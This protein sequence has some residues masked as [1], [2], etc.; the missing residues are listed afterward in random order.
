MTKTTRNGNSSSLFECI[1]RF[2]C[3]YADWCNDAQTK[4]ENALSQ[5]GHYDV[6]NEE[7]ATIAAPSYCDLSDDDVGKCDV[8]LYAQ[9]N[10]PFKPMPVFASRTELEPKTTMSVSLP[11]DTE[12]RQNDTMSL[13][14]YAE[15]TRLRQKKIREKQ[16]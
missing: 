2:F 16:K 8:D 7:Q 3:C 4:N 6:L 11:A 1:M 15:L 13:G 12:L 14:A 5:N 9:K 10:R